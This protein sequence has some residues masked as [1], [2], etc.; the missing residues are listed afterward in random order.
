MWEGRSSQKTQIFFYSWWRLCRQTEQ[1]GN[2]ELYQLCSWIRREWRS[3]GGRMGTATI[4]LSWRQAATMPASSVVATSPVKK[5]EWER[6]GG[7]LDGSQSKRT[8]SSNER[9]A[10]D[11]RQQV[12]LLCLTGRVCHL[13]IVYIWYCIFGSQLSIMWTPMKH[14]YSYINKHTV[15]SPI[16]GV[17]CALIHHKNS[18]EDN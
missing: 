7:I 10:L 5:R 17:A 1:G 11:R 9:G 15:H 13:L 2:V 4:W 3:R 14:S 12:D 8:Q 16:C 18:A 6:G